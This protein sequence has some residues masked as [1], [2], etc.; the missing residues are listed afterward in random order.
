L[1]RAGGGG[2]LLAF[3]LDAAGCAD[4]LSVFFRFGLGTFWWSMPWSGRARVARSGRA[5][6]KILRSSFC[7]S[8]PVWWLFELFNLRT[9]NWEYLGRDL[10]TPLQ[11][12]LLCTI[13]FSIV[14]PAVFETAELIQTFRWMKAFQVRAAGACNAAGFCRFVYRWSRYAHIGNGLAENFL[15]VHLDFARFDFR[16]G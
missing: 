3:E 13:A 15:S 6:A 14:V 7:F 16:A 2:G 4:G 9:A 5:H 11:Y 1:G 10:F 8:A 12:N